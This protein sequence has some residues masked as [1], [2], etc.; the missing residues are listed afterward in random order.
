[1]IGIII[2]LVAFCCVMLVGNSILDAI[3]LFIMAVLCLVNHFIKKSYI[4]KITPTMNFIISCCYLTNRASESDDY[5]IGGMVKGTVSRLKMRRA[6][7]GSWGI[8]NKKKFN[9]TI[10]WLWEEGHNKGCLEEMKQYQGCTQDSPNPELFQKLL[11][12]YPE[13]GIL[14]WDLCRLCNVATW[15]TIAGYMK[16]KDAISLCVRAGKMLQ[17][18]FDSW[19]DMIDNYLTG[20]WYWSGDKEEAERRKEWYDIQRNY[21][22]SLLYRS[23]F[24]M[25]L[26]E[27]DIIKQRISVFL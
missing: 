2:L 18:N 1:M 17:D 25:N 22:K 15:G 20:L 12:D 10:W 6:L 14:A 27:N 9:Q 13:K 5:E 4:K 16:Y 7:K 19:D 11:D 26:D 23:D 21:E 3:L 8:K 24:K